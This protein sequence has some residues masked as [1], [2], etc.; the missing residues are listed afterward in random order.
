[1]KAN[2]YNTW[3]LSLPMEAGYVWVHNI[4]EDVPDVQTLAQIQDDLAPGMAAYGHPYVFAFR[5]GR[6]K[7][8]RAA[9]MEMV[10]AAYCIGTWTGFT[11]DYGDILAFSNEHDAVRYRLFAADVLAA[12]PEL[13]VHVFQ[14]STLQT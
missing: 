14:P 8:W 3:L 5:F 13:R 4:W 7:G 9:L 2:E 6:P 12:G 1:M 11:C 10:E